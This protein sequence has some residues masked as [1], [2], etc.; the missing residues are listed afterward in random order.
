MP[1]Y[2]SPYERV[3]AELLRDA[4]PCGGGIAVDVGCNDG[5]F[6][7]MLP[8]A[9]YDTVVGYDTDE[10]VLHEARRTHPHI[11]FRCG[12]D[13]FSVRRRSLSLVL[14]VVEHIPP[15]LQLGFLRG[16]RAATVDGGMLVL[17]TPSRYSLLATCERLRRLHQRGSVPYS[18]WDDTHVSVLS[19]GGLHRLVR[20]AGFRVEHQAGLCFAPPHLVH[21]RVTTGAL[22]RFAFDV[23]IVARAV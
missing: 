10:D 11:D 15:A 23:L 8:A 9:G 21:P 1:E 2:D 3:R 20:A 6:T 22:T 14:E 13:D 19:Y 7:A 17:S 18:W 4:L 12:Q 5:R 16:V